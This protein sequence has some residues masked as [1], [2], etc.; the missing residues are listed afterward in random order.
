MSETLDR[1]VENSLRPVE[2]ISRLAPYRQGKS[3]LE[4]IAD[5]IKLSSNESMASFNVLISDFLASRSFSLF[6]L[7]FLHQSNCSSGWAIHGR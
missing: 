5:P 2:G 6:F 4:G 7:S 3:Q 1:P